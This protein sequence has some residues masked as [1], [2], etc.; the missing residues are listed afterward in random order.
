M[1][2]ARGGGET[3][4]AQQE[5]DGAQIGATLEQV[6]SGKHSLRGVF[7]GLGGWPSRGPKAGED[8]DR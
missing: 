4:V 8:A 5:L 2:V 3:T 1:Q 7:W 6:H